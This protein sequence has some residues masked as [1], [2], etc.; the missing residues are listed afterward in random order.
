[1]SD[2]RGLT[3][4]RRSR[5]VGVAFDLRAAVS[6]IVHR[7]SVIHVEQA[8]Y[9]SFPFRGQGYA[10]LSAS[11]GCRAEWLADF[12]AAC[13]N[14][15]ERP[16]SAAETPALFALRLPSGPW[17]VAGV[18]PQGRDDRGR[19]GALAFHGL[20]LSPRAYRSFEAD[21]FR[22]ADRL[23]SDWKA[24]TSL[25]S[26]TLEPRFENPRPPTAD[27]PRASRIATALMKGRRVAIE[28]PGPIGG[29]AREVWRELPIRVRKRSSVATWA[30]SNGN[31]FNLMAAP[32]LVGM[33]FDRSYLDPLSFEGVLDHGESSV[34]AG[35]S[36]WVSPMALTVLGV[37]AA[38]ALAGVGMSL[39]GWDDAEI[40]VPQVSQD[41]K[42][43]VN[44]SPSSALL[45]PDTAEDPDER[46]RATE[47]ISNLADRFEIDNVGEVRD[48]PSATMERLSRVLRYR[49]PLLSQSERALLALEPDHDAALALRWDARVRGFLDDRPLPPGFRTGPIRRQIE[50]LAWSF[51]AENEVRNADGTTPKR[52]AAEVVQALAETLAVD[53][54]LRPT[55]LTN[56]FPALA[57]YLVFLNR[58][59]RR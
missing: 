51:H 45:S 14:L 27:D 44:P 24:D 38:L 32:R 46:L 47:A 13:Q 33:T 8:V 42:A 20:F 17:V 3:I 30:F 54:P 59:P 22:L 19:P 35:P 48:D 29:L 58:L 2:D 11:P 34:P 9:G 12:R 43:F 50:T 53:L 16:A 55:S 6:A 10:M 23:K 21:P 40:P 56:R 49:G 26:M 31:V 5:R 37:S 57:D 7:P 52:S 15:G 1:M 4:D 18:F 36:L 25:T 39:R 28:A 41:T